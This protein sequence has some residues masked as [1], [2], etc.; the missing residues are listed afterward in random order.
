MPSLGIFYFMVICLIAQKMG[1]EEK[2]EIKIPQRFSPNNL[3]LFHMIEK[4]SCNVSFRL[5]V[6]RYSF[7]FQLEEEKKI[8]PFPE[9]LRN[10]QNW[11]SCWPYSH[12]NWRSFGSYFGL[13]K[14]H[15]LSFWTPEAQSSKIRKKLQLWEVVLFLSHNAGP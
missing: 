15:K 14:L 4:V 2:V 1:H 9:Y 13:K 11:S 5:T 3:R 12:N 8:L 7:I 6:Y 10:F